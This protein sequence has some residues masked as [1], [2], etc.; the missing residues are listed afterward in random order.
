MD[1]FVHNQVKNFLLPSSL[2]YSSSI[3]VSALDQIRF[4]ETGFSFSDSRRRRRSAR[5]W[6]V[7]HTSWWGTSP[8]TS[9]DTSEEDGLF[10]Q[11]VETRPDKKLKRERKKKS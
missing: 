4:T 11:T 3:V 1:R 8:P 5:F 10:G 2:F 9:G 6:Q 7:D